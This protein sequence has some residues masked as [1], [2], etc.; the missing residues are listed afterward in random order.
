MTRKKNK[1]MTFLWSLIPGAGEMYLGFFKQGSTL[2]AAFFILLGIAGFLQLNFLSFLAP[3]IWFYSF[4]HTNNLNTLPDEEF[5]AID[6]DYMIH[7]SSLTSNQ[8]VIK[9]Y[10]KLLAGCLI[11]FGAS[12]LWNNFNHLLFWYLLPMLNLTEE[13]GRLIRYIANSIPQAIVAI[14]V[15]IAGVYLIK[16][17]YEELKDDD[18]IIPAPPYLKDKEGSL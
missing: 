11:F 18:S 5:Y 2:M 8:T 10:R 12:I 16:G 3:L 15:I 13:A 17:K 9:K 14:A 1:L 6:D 7:W 4:F